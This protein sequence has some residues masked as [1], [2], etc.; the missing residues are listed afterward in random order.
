MAVEATRAREKG[1]SRQFPEALV[2]TSFR[3]DLALFPQ[4]EGALAGRTDEE[5][6]RAG[7][8]QQTGDES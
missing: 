7:D 1:C 6:T 2:R 8:D 3:S 4:R 5:L